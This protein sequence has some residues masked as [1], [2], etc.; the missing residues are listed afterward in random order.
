MP[1][2]QVDAK[3]E[4]RSDVPQL[5]LNGLPKTTRACRSSDRNRMEAHVCSH[6]GTYRRKESTY[7][8]VA[9]PSVWG[10]SIPTVVLLI[11][12]RF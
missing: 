11:I 9:V 3:L 1:S 5:L 12:N 6:R 2:S 10:F 7:F 4:Q 8:P